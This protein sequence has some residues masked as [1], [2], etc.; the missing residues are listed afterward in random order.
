MFTPYT[1][2]A[3][4]LVVAL[5]FT[6]SARPAGGPYT[7]RIRVSFFFVIFFGQFQDE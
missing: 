1:V 2:L 7:D 5:Y 4:V 3:W 6:L